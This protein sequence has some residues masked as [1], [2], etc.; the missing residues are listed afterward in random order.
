MG[1]G[2][3]IEIIKKPIDKIIDTVTDVGKG[4]VNAVGG[5]VGGVVDA[6][7][8]PF[9]MDVTIPDYDVGVDQT[10]AIQGVLLN[11][12]SGVANVPVV[13]GTRRVGGIRVFVA[14]S[15]KTNEFLYVAFILSEGQISGFTK[16]FIDDNEV[17]L[18]SYA[19]NVQAN[20]TTARYKDRVKI[21]FMDGRDDQPASSLL[22]AAPG[23]TS[24]HRLQGLAYLACRFKLPKITTQEESD[25][26]PF[27]GGIPNIKAQINGKLVFDVTT[28]GSDST[29]AK[30]ASYEDATKVFSKNPV[31]VLC[32][33]LQ[34]PR[35]GKAL[36]NDAFDW[37]SFK[38]AADQ[39]DQTVTYTNGSTSNAFTS[40]AVIDTAINLMTN[41][42]IMLANFRGL[43]PYQQGKYFLKV[44]NG[45]DDT[46]ITATPSDPDTAMTIT[47]D[48]ILSGVSIEG[49]NKANKLNRVI[50]TYVDSS[51]D[52]QPNEVTF[53]IAGSDT[54]T[55]FLEED[56]KRLEARITL[57]HCANRAIAE[58]YAQVYL[59]KS[60]NSKV[61]SFATSLATSDVSVGDIVRVINSFIG[62]DGFF[63]V[64]EM[65]L[66]TSGAMQMQAV[67]HQPTAYAIG[68]TGDDY[69]RPTLSFPDP[70][71]L[72][73]VTNLSA[74]NTFTP[75]YTW[76]PNLKV[77]DVVAPP[78]TRFEIVWTASESPQVVS[79]RVQ[80]K[81]KNELNYKEMA[82]V[83]G[84]L[85][86]VGVYE[87]EAGITYDIR[88]IALD[89][90]F[91]QS[92]AVEIEHTTEPAEYGSGYRLN[93]ET[94][95]Y[96][97]DGDLQAFK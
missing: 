48:H 5:V 2:G 65:R 28:L 46:D 58:Q 70:L 11:V 6:V 95:E 97:V 66:T 61:V 13:Y 40:D 20:A 91:V 9:S 10:Q 72:Q 77:L 54:D 67:E 47:N 19:H 76:P 89:K 31:N 78:P 49:E 29:A 33:Y 14:T 18:S 80:M 85:H 87:S 12:D 23:W 17:N 16:L 8:S 34:N 32:D 45:G 63:R 4:V 38:V 74:V 24:Q 79:Y 42:K 27:T 52:F 92:A 36:D 41:V 43:M 7:T 64:T 69:V 82:I 93:E 62:L 35:F 39:C 51:A 25:A 1:G 96:E 81:Q 60:R 55:Q 59:R 57:P 88:V 21:Q 71:S 83:E 53:P 73:P 37:P 84:T 90:D 3:P 26:N 94:G 50:V 68:A 15:G 30:T 22:S 75:I 56:G 44:E 86:K